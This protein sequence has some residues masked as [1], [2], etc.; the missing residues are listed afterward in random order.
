MNPTKKIS[1]V[2]GLPVELESTD[3]RWLCFDDGGV[4]VEVGEFLYGLVRAIKP[5][6]ICETGLYSGISCMYMAMALKENGFGHIDSIEYEEKH[7]TRSKERLLKMKLVDY[8]T[9]YHE[10]SLEFITQQNYDLLLLDTEL[11]LRFKELV[12]F[13]P[14]LNDGGIALIHDMP[15]NFCQGNINSD[16]PEFKNWPVGDIPIEVNK[17]IK[18]DRL[19]SIHFKTARGLVGFYKTQKGEYQ[20]G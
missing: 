6:R 10:S 2:L 1:Q 8:V 7:I 3:R 11:N 18:D 19:R 15:I 20:W 12:R 4:E 17:L 5:Q 14:S 16:H 13:Y 9:I